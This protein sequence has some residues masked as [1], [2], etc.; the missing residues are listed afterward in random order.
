MS[1]IIGEVTASIAL[2]G[3]VQ[4]G[5]SY[6]AYE[7]SYEIEPSAGTQVLPT[8]NRLMTEDITVREIAYQEVTNSSG[9]KTITIGG[10]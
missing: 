1:D 6:P 8:R 3:T 4:A 5:G 9:G 10:N 2:E 7:G